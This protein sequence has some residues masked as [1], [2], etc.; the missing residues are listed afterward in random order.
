MDRDDVLAIIEAAYAAR[1]RGDGEAVNRIWAEGATFETAGEKTL[2]EAFPGAEPTAGQLAAEAIM[3]LVAMTSRKTLQAV[4]E[5]R[6]AAILSQATV[7]FAG[8]EPFETL[9]YDLWELDEAGKVRSLLQFAD[10]AK[11]ASELQALSRS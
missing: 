2:I 6:R 9:L 5:G 3:R 7:S 4:V 11:I 10:T 1:M 8:R